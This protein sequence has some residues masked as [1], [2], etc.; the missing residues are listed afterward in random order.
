MLKKGDKIVLM[1]PMGEFD[2]VGE[3]C[4]V[5]KVLD[6]GTISFAFGHGLHLGVMSED[7]FEKYF[8]VYEEPVKKVNNRVTSDVVDDIIDNSEVI[9]DTLFG[10]CTMVALRMP[11]SFVIVETSACVDPANY[12]EDLGFEICMGRIRSKIYELEG[13]KLCDELHKD[14]VDDVDDDSNNCKNCEWQDVCNGELDEYDDVDDYDKLRDD[15]EYW[16]YIA[17]KY[18]SYFD[19]VDDVLDSVDDIVKRYRGRI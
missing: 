16:D 1:K 13:Y 11:N 10:N 6:D 5:T 4:T 9:V 8:K 14:Y 12:D 2:N 18:D 19:C 3:V 15:D 7:E 17:S